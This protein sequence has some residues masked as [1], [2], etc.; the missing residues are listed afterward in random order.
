MMTKP[1]SVAVVGLGNMGRYHVT[2]YVD[3]E[4]AQLTA[5]CDPHQPLVD[6]FSQ[7][8]HCCGYHTIDDM[9]ACE[10]L[11]A[12]SITSPTRT[13]FELAMKAIDAGVSVLIEK[14]ITDSVADA[15]LLLDR[16]K[17][18]GVTVMVGHI[19]RFNPA[20]VALKNL[21][22][23][24]QLGS[25]TSVI[26]RRVGAFPTQIKDANVIIDLAVHD[27][28]VISYLLNEQP[29]SINGSA[30]RALIDGREDHAELF[31]TYP[32]QSAYIQVN[33]ITPIRIRQ[34]ALTGT[35]GYIE[36]DYLNQTL[37]YYES[38][39]AHCDSG[40]VQFE[41]S[42]RQDIPVIKQNALLSELTH[43]LTC[44]MT[45]QTPIVSGEMGCQALMTA[46]AAMDQL[47]IHRPA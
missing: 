37:H 11:D 44:V 31:L 34:L 14:P 12:V 38:N 28:D 1:L 4:L 45:K 35:Q 13:H 22:D 9:L 16:A 10:S 19:E 3:S 47:S 20:V 25:I 41:P 33:W 42:V 7:Q 40:T 23:S 17:Q 27:I 46:L 15:E 21:L 39:Y 2:N 6:S 32:N 26:A 24:N 18:Q 30:G 43:F 8:F 5:V 36:L 29:T